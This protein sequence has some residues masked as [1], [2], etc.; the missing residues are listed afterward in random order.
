MGEYFGFGYPP[1]RSVERSFPVCC[2]WLRAGLK[3]LCALQVLC[4][5]SVVVYF[6]GRGICLWLG[7]DFRQGALSWLEITF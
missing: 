4:A 7:M 5:P 1:S 3:G 6:P 2:E